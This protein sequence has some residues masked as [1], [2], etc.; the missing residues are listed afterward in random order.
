MPRIFYLLFIFLT[1]CTFVSEPIVV[2]RLTGTAVPAPTDTPTL[3]APP[4]PTL[5]ATPPAPTP[6]PD[7]VTVA[8][9]TTTPT[10][11]ATVTAVPTATPAISLGEFLT[12]LQNNLNAHDFEA[13]QDMVVSRFVLGQYA[14]QRA[15]VYPKTVAELS[16]YRYV[17]RVDTNIVIN[18]EDIASELPEPFAVET[19]FRGPLGQ[20]ITAVVTSSGWGQT[21]KGEMIL[22][23]SL[24]NGQY[25]WAGLLASPDYYALPNLETIAPPPG[26][27]YRQRNE[28]WHI[29]QTGEPQLMTTFSGTLTFNPSGTLAL[30][31]DTDDNQLTLLNL[32]DGLTETISIEGTLLHGSWQ[33]PWLDDETAVL[34]VGAPDE[35]IT[36]SSTGNLAALNVLDG[37]VMSYPPVLSL[38]SQPSTRNGDILYNDQEGGCVYGTVVMNR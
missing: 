12:T 1:A 6:I 2:T 15:I 14:T 34:I 28:L 35:D 21:G 3:T 19:I 9:A 31:A 11:T 5:T 16:A 30:Y 17:S 10:A 18:K 37:T 27:T 4:L 24:Q 33:M 23:I 26:L 13:L 20:T 25:L 38:Y 8:T 29:N 32:P 22:Y 36:Q 7:T